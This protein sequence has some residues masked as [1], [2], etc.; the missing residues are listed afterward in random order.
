MQSAFRGLTSWG[1]VAVLRRLMEANEERNRL[2]IGDA[3]RFV[4]A[5]TKRA[6]LLITLAAVFFE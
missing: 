5:T 4:I 6:R 2:I 3:A 1:A